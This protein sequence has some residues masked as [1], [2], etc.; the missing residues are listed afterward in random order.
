MIASTVWLSLFMLQSR[1]E[2]VRWKC[3]R[4]KK[5]SIN[6]G[7]NS[8]YNK[9]KFN[10]TDMKYKAFPKTS[11]QNKIKPNQQNIKEPL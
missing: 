2:N 9:A 1:T 11:A 4:N 10:L 6:P 7:E 5:Y 3:Y 8:L